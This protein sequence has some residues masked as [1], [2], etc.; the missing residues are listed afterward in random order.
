ME[1]IKNLLPSLAN[2][3][4]LDSSSTSLNLP[5]LKQLTPEENQ[6][7]R[8]KYSGVLIGKMSEQQVAVTSGALLFKIHA[9]TGWIIPQENV[10]AIFVDQF[11]KKLIESYPNCNT[12][13]IE[14]AFRTHGSAVK[15]WGKQMNLS[16]IDEVMGIYLERRLAVS[17]FEESQKKPVQRIY[18][19]EQLNNI[20]RADAEAAYQRMLR[21]R[22]NVVPGGAFRDILTLDGYIDEET[23]LALWLSERIGKGI[24][25][26]YIQE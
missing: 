7:L 23:D 8:I 15:D 1:Q 20:K 5:T 9:I 14:Y 24:K 6:L 2:M 3:Q 12:D 4:E 18:S 16:L 13:E 10:L 11:T 17:R 25:N 26:L 22:Q 19:D 21:G